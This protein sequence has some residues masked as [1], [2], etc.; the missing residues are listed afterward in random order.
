MTYKPPNAKIPISVYF[1]RRGSFRSFK[2]H[3]GSTTIAKSVAKPTAAF[4]NQ[5]GALV[6]HFPLGF[7]KSQKADAGLQVKILVKSCM[8]HHDTM[9]IPKPQQTRRIVRV[10]LIRRS[11]NSAETFTAA[12]PVL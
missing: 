1:C 8:S 2:M 4:E 11:C 5:K 6:T 10:T 7:L 9:K 12:S 3:I